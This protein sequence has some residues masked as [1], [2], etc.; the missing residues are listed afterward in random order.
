MFKEN[1]PT[2]TQVWYCL[3]H[4]N[5]CRQRGVIGVTY[6]CY[7]RNHTRS[8]TS[9]IRRSSVPPCAWVGPTT[10]RSQPNTVAKSEA[11]PPWRFVVAEPNHSWWWLF[12]SPTNRK[13][14]CKSSVCTV[15]QLLTLFNSRLRVNVNSRAFSS[16]N[17]VDRVLLSANSI[18]LN[19]EDEFGRSFINIKNNNGKRTD[20][21]GTPWLGEEEEEVIPSITVIWFLSIRYDLSRSCEIPLIP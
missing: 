7:N 16:A 15:S 5:D 6:G 21:C 11:A 18:N 19:K 12:K 2:N 9:V 20:P 14:A 4:W 13:E 17:E 3:S 8:G 1:F 10:N